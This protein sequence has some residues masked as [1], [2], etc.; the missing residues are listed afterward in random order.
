MADVNGV[1]GRFGDAMD[2]QARSD[3]DAPS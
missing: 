3:A 1:S 2:H